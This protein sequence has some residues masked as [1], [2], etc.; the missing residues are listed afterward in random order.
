MS[1]FK[2]RCSPP[3]NPTA[4]ILFVGHYHSLQCSTLLCAVA[5]VAY[6]AHSCNVLMLDSGT[7]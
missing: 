2:W 7:S 3:L 1:T 6:V 5:T 4:Y